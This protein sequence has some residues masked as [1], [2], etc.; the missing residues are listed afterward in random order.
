[1][2]FQGFLDDIIQRQA[3]GR[4]SEAR[5]ISY[6]TTGN[7]S[8][9]ERDDSTIERTGTLQ[10]YAGSNTIT[11]YA[12]R[13]NREDTWCRINRHYH[14]LARSVVTTYRTDRGDRIGNRLGLVRM[15]DELIGND[16]VY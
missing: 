16:V 7:S 10:L 12:V 5:Y 8:V 3:A 11:L 9:L 13:G 15:V 6:T 1:M 2:I 14:R 4:R